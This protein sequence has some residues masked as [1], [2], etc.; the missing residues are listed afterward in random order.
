MAPTTVPISHCPGG[1][2]S[3]L[4][5]SR[6]LRI[7]LTV[8]DLLRLESALILVH[9]M[10]S[11]VLSIPDYNV[12]GG[13]AQTRRGVRKGSG[14][15]KLGSNEWSLGYKVDGSHVGQHRVTHPWI[16]YCMR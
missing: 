6:S 3:T 5:H 2:P 10:M 11:N 16:D 12:H 9:I 13:Q 8:Y 14:P 4:L 7:Y 1:R 15:V